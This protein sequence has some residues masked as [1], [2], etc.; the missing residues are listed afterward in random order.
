M[1]H[2]PVNPTG[3]IEIVEATDRD[4]DLALFAA[5]ARP[6]DKV[7]EI[8]KR[9]RSMR[10]YISLQK[11]TAGPCLIACENGGVIAAVVTLKA[12][13]RAAMV[14]ATSAGADSRADRALPDLLKEAKH[15]AGA[16]GVRIL[17]VLLTAQE[18]RQDTVY[19]GAGFFHLA[20]LIYLD[21][22]IRS[23]DLPCTGARDLAWL[24]YEPQHRHL[25]TQAVA[26]T[27][28]GSLDCPDLH[29]LRSI[30]DIMA[31]HESTG[32]HDPDLWFL[33]MQHHK[34]AGVMM[35][36]RAIGASAGE[37][38]YMGVLPGA[39]GQG[40]GNALMAKAIEAC[41]RRDL[42]KLTLAVDAANDPALR[43]YRRF[44]MEEVTRRH[45]WIASIGPT[46]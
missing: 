27:Y 46:T 22:F 7:G 29:G 5:L 33:A 12:P 38:V 41:A 42:A 21:M 3:H 40:V 35:V 2:E 23:K 14:L 45:A 26:A 37:V 36:S 30:E 43:I 17:Q 15:R 10:E 28:E 19:V 8:S 18:H 25:F 9:V 31:S 32:L 39:R 24:T 20:E 11:I 6:G 1:N 4:F 13:G 16:D 44:G 34:P